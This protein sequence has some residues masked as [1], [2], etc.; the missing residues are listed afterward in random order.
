M[1]CDK[2]P[3][4]N[5]IC[6]MGLRLWSLL[7]L[8]GCLALPATALAREKVAVIISQAVGVGPLAD[9]LGNLTA[10]HLG[11]GAAK[12]V[13]P[14][15]AA[16]LLRER[17]G[18]EPEACGSDVDCLRE[19]ARALE[20]RWV[21]A[22]G[23]GS[24]GEIF[25]LELRCVEEDE[26]VE[27][28]ATS[29]TYA[30]PG[31]DWG[32]ALRERL[33]RVVPK[34]LLFSR[35]GLFIDSEEVGAEIRVNDLTAGTVPLAQP[36]RLPEGSYTVELR[37]A[38]YASAQE[39][40]EIRAGE[41]TELHLELLPIA[42]APTPYRT[43]AYVGAGTTVAALATAIG[44]HVSASGAMSDARDLQKA[45]EPFADERDGAL[46]RM[47]AARVVY[48][49]AGAAAIA[50]GVLYYLDLQQSAASP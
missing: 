13:G 25:S 26:T 33:E 3:R 5:T 37:Q 23:V 2:P 39:T 34:R 36:L 22:L 14:G 41:E 40:V 9:H 16:R 27:A 4:S 50:T 29:A 10:E 30:A 43:Y 18:P 28:T 49:V 42:G 35:G 47:Q 24:F 48:G 6:I 44:L 46:G 31:P 38:G 15:E 7:L 12:V 32:Q 8:I 1:R 21:V 45:G 20:T 19:V 17:G 11:K